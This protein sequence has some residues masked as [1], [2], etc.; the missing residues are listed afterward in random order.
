MPLPT[1]ISPLQCTRCD[2][3]PDDIRINPPASGAERESHS[4]ATVLCEQ[5]GDEVVFYLVLH[6]PGCYM[7]ERATGGA[8]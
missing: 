6:K 8:S 4:P 3:E 2:R 5:E 7:I 1:R